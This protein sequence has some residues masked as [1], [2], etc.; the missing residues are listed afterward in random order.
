M[1][2]D[3]CLL[4]GHIIPIW[5]SYLGP[6]KIG[7]VELQIKLLIKKSPQF[8]DTIWIKFMGMLD[9]SWLKWPVCGFAPSPHK[10]Q[11]FIQKLW[12]L[13]TSKHLSNF[14]YAPHVLLTYKDS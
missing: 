12:V 14:A 1:W 6:E 11:W 9:L 3:S 7:P 13:S 2:V 5:S 10:I 8:I 4:N